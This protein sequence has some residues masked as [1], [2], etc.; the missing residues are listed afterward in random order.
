M[1][2]KCAPGGRLL[3]YSGPGCCYKGR[4]S[5][6]PVRIESSGEV[7]IRTALYEVSL[8]LFTP[9]AAYTGVSHP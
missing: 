7:E 2:L 1:L 9:A 3:L 4:A 8:H 6:E 5:C